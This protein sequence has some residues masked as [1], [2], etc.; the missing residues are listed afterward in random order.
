MGSTPI[1]VFTPD[2][3]NSANPPLVYYIHADHLDT[4]RLVVDKD[5][6]QRWS[7]FAEPFGTT[8]PNSNPQGLGAFT[9]NL[10]FP[11]QYADQEAGLFYN[12]FRDYDAS[13]GRYVQSD[14]IGLAGGINT[15][16]YTLNQPTKYTDPEGLFPFLVIPGI[17]AAG[18]C[19]TLL[20]GGAGWWAMQNALPR[21]APPGF[22]SA[23]N[24]EQ[25]GS[26]P[27]PCDELRRQLDRVYLAL[28]RLQLN[29]R[30]PLET[31]MQYEFEYRRFKKQFEDVCGPY[32][33]PVTAPPEPP[34]DKLH[35]FYGR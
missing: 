31:K 6:N 18:G 3:A 13:T 9:L 30:I 28:T 14:P 10:R 15:F 4:P 1:A 29:P 32:Q 2:P 5:S 26:C 27:P 19:E 34:I 23:A 12:Y 17:C 25:Y 7:W 21:P 33:P 8:V 11:G 20:L 16:A 22:P 24:D 35:D